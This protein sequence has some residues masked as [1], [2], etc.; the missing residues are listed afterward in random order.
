MLKKSIVG[1]MCSIVLLM[2]MSIGVQAASFSYKG[3]VIGNGVRL[4]SIPD[5]GTVLELMYKGETVYVDKEMTE[6]SAS[7]SY[8]L[9]RS[10]TG[11]VGYADNH[12]IDVPGIWN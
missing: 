6:E 3:T 11:T 8:Y 7:G 5:A 4:R 12:Y 10:K 1:C 9:K 2:S